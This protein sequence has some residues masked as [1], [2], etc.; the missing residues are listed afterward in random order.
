MLE[1]DPGSSVKFLETNLDLGSPRSVSGPGAQPGKDQ[2]A[3]WFP[4]RD[5][6]HHERLVGVHFE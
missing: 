4:H 1:H 5:L 3:S 2:S 6:S